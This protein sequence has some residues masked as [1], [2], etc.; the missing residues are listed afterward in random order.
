MDNDGYV[1]Q[2]DFAAFQACY[3]GVDDPDA[4]YDFDACRCMNSD[5]DVD[6]DA[7]DLDA[8][9]ACAS[10]PEVPGDVTCDDGLSPP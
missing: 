6:I 1:A 9:E 8:F 2:E 10:G 7:T 5:G 3:T 4:V